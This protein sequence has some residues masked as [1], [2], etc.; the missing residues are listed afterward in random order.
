MYYDERGRHGAVNHLDSVYVDGYSKQERGAALHGAVAIKLTL[1]HE[2][3]DWAT[4][5]KIV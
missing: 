3:P 2:A 4:N 1:N 5:W